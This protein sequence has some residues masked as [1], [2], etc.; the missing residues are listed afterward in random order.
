MCPFMSQCSPMV[1]SVNPSLPGSGSDSLLDETSCCS[2]VRCWSEVNDKFGE[3]RR[4]Q[5]K[6]GRGGTIHAQIRLACRI[7]SGCEFESRHSEMLD[8]LEAGDELDMGRILNISLQKRS[9]K[10]DN[11]YKCVLVKHLIHLSQ[12]KIKM[13]GCI[14]KICGEL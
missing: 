7:T 10:E 6:A 8:A 9:K 2:A 12:Q 4:D 1:W 13:Y 5:I 14:M 11:L 3:P